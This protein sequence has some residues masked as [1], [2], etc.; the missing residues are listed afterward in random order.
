[1]PPKRPLSGTN[2]YQSPPPTQRDTHNGNDLHLSP[3]PGH[4]QETPA[5]AAM[6]N[7]TPPRSTVRNEDENLSPI[8]ARSPHA[9]QTQAGGGIHAIALPAPAATDETNAAAATNAMQSGPQAVM[10]PDAVVNGGARAAY[11]VSQQQRIITC[12]LANIPPSKRHI[13]SR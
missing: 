8:S 7:T 11:Q 5:D 13:P 1:M 12:N 9:T 4:H 6:A 3:M 2:D 10:Q